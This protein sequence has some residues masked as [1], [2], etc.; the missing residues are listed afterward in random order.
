MSSLIRLAQEWPPERVSRGESLAPRAGAGRPSRPRRQGQRRPPHTRGYRACVRAGGAVGPWLQRPYN[1]VLHVYEGGR[2]AGSTRTRH[3]PSTHCAARAL[4]RAPGYGTGVAASA[5]MPLSMSVTIGVGRLASSASSAAIASSQRQRCRC[6]VAGMG[7]EY[8]YRARGTEH[9][10]GVGYG[11]RG[12][13]DSGGVD[14]SGDDG[15]GIGGVCV[16]GVGGGGG[17]GS[18]GDGEGSRSDLGVS[19]AS[20]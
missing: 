12:G 13:G 17:G 1:S 9:G 3:P 5:P 8:G 15:S 6:R 16:G 14:G 7:A 20:A 18:G 2:G 19:A 10:V 11:D 4:K